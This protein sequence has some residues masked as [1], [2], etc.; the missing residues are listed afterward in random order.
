MSSLVEQHHKHFTALC[1]DIESQLSAD[2]L[3]HSERCEDDSKRI[4]DVCASVDTRLT[5][6]IDA[7]TSRMDKLQTTMMQHHELVTEA[8]GELNR[9]FKADMADLEELLQRNCQ[10][11]TERCVTADQSA[12]DSKAAQDTRMDS[13]QIAIQS[14]HEHFTQVC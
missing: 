2:R 11:L 7:H 3:A 8:A 9:R 12:T 5:D 14:Q 13:L 4:L 1:T 10:H 6:R